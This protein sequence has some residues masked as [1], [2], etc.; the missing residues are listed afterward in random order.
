MKKLFL[1]VMIILP[2]MVVAQT[3]SNLSV[4]PGTPGTVTF[5]V[6]WNKADLDLKTLW[7]DS[8]WVFVDYN[9]NGKME[10]MLLESGGTLL[11]H[12]ATKSGT[13]IFIEE[14]DNDKGAWVYGDAR[15][16]GSFSA[17]VQLLTLTADLA[18]AC[19]YA[20][21][22]PPVGDWIDET[23]IAFTGTPWY[24]IKL[25]HSDGSTVET[26]ESGGT[27]L[28]PC[29][30]TVSSFTDKTGAP[31]ILGCIPSSDIFNLT[32]SATTYCVGGTVTFALDNTTPGR[33]YQLYK[34]GDAV[35]D[36]LTGTGS[37]ETFT[38]TFAGP[39][40]YAARVKDNGTYCAAQMTGTHA[41][42]ES[43]APTPTGTT[44]ISR[45]GPGTITFSASADGNAI[46]WYTLATGGSIVS[47]GAGVASFSPSISGL[48]RYFAQARSTAGCVSPA[49]LMVTATVN[50]IPVISHVAASGS[51]TQTVN[52]GSGI[53]NIRYAATNAT[54]FSG[55]GLPPGVSGTVTGSSYTIGGS[56][57]A[58]GT[59]NYSVTATTS[60]GCTSATAATGTITVYPSTPLLA[61][62]TRT[63]IYAGLGWSD[64]IIGTP[65]GCSQ[66]N[67]LST[68][69]YTLAECNG[70]YCSWACVKATQNTLCPSPW[71][72]PTKA[73]FDALVSSGPGQA[74]LVTEWGV[75]NNYQGTSFINPNWAYYWSSEEYD[76]RDA[77]YLRYANFG[78]YLATWTAEKCS[79][80][81]VRCVRDL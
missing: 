8:V 13:G 69:D 49:R 59:Y 64:V 43:S 53:V 54:S 36:A 55:S 14:P 11:V 31:G 79:G 9:K 65:S 23:R 10:R 37:A 39:G 12:S 70:H 60:Y 21:S 44:S 18:G 15:S 77:Y 3:V 73:D 76:S 33:T 35:M 28:V 48:T 51:V 74:T 26:V 72:V 42:S 25:L 24:E 62:S 7:L 16:A 22:Y 52:R 30:Y 50:P 81:R 38:G 41:V 75:T 61:A 56:P 78:S 80:H 32:V 27:F 2:A 57:S 45:C 34:D 58:T 67:T 66:T 46:D 6:E 47:G 19:A 40:N 4:I 1:S 17:K 29:S 63:W 20:S 71:R 68:T 5:D